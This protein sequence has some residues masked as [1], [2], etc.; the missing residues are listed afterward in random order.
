MQAASC[1]W[2]LE[3]LSDEALGQTVAASGIRLTFDNLEVTHTANKVEFIA[4][5]NESSLGD[6][7][8]GS[9]GLVNLGITDLQM[10]GRVDILFSPVALGSGTY[11][12]RDTYKGG[13]S[14]NYIHMSD[15]YL[16]TRTPDIDTKSR[17]ALVM[18]GHGDVTN[19]FITIA[20]V[21]GA[22]EVYHE[23]ASPITN[24]KLGHLEVEN[25]QLIDQ[26]MTLYSLPEIDG[27]GSVGGIAMELGLRLSIEDVKITSPVDSSTA[28]LSLHGIH[29]RE[30]FSYDYGVY[31]KF[32]TYSSFY[33][34]QL[35]NKEKNK[36]SIN[37]MYQSSTGKYDLYD[38][39]GHYT[40]SEEWHFDTSITDP[41][42]RA[43][44]VGPKSMYGGRFML[45]NLRQVGFYDF[46]AGNGDLVSHH[47]TFHESQLDLGDDGGD[48]QNKKIDDISILERPMSFSFKKR[49]AEE[50]GGACLAINMPLHGAIRVEEVL[51]YN[52]PDLGQEGYLGG[53]S[54]GP[55]I[56]DGIR[57]KKLYM[58]FPGRGQEYILT[59]NIKES[60]TEVPDLYDYVYEAGALPKEQALPLNSDGTERQAPYNPMGRG[61]EWALTQ[62]TDD[63]ALN[64]TG[65]DQYETRIGQDEFWQIRDPYP[66]DIHYFD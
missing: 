24:Y 37:N 23:N 51:G 41:W 52:S 8:R 49:S 59:T 2:A 27:Y 7:G 1:A 57:V 39:D 58:E 20:S 46:I 44:G 65:W 55:M 22:I 21:D 47:D 31:D 18:G 66:R 50:G 54:M 12:V 38:E 28:N 25:T 14:D 36:E 34:W 9:I 4:Y 29:L 42:G 61:V 64:G 10:D 62:L 6:S 3:P 16:I 53:N 32:G 63:G 40:I 15:D 48:K 56:V 17:D 45:G 43:T 19:P 26:N 60:M 11:H 13:M 33:I 30:G 5:D 35:I